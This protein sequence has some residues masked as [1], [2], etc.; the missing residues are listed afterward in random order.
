V[1]RR[2]NAVGPNQLRSAQRHSAWQILLSQF[3]RLI[4]A[5]LQVA[6]AL[7]FAFGQTVEGLAVVTVIVINAAT[8]RPFNQPGG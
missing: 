5:L 2:R 8:C 3:K 4:V 6:T 1:K 7:S